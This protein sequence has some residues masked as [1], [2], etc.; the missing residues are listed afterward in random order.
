MTPIFSTLVNFGPYIL[1][2]FGKFS[3]SATKDHKFCGP[4]FRNKSY[5]V[6]K[7]WNL[8]LIFSKL[9]N[10]GPH[11]LALLKSP[12]EELKDT[13]SLWAKVEKRT[14]FWGIKFWQWFWFSRNWWTLVHIFWHFWKALGKGNKT[15]KF[16]GPKFINKKII[17][18][19]ILK[20]GPNFLKTGKLWTI[21]FGIVG[22]RS[23]RLQNT[24]SLWAKVQ[25][26]EVLG[27]QI[28]T[29]I[30]IFSIP[31]NFGPH[32]LTFLESFRER[33]QATKSLWAKVQKQKSY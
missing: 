17:E 1:T 19:S 16:C 14:K 15:P 7:F 33:L 32:I 26:H 21:Y 10:F 20:F 24:Q 27:G 12:R 13:Q 28:L 6:I 2:F 4:K 18:W 9:V 11:S 30:P 5:S 3:G 22:K 31:V 23:K 8:V 25:K 29:I